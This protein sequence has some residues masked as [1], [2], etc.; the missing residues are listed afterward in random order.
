MPPAFADAEEFHELFRAVAAEATSGDD[1]LELQDSAPPPT[2]KKQKPGIG[3]VRQKVC[4]EDEEGLVGFDG[5]EW[6]ILRGKGKDWEC[7]PRKVRVREE[8]EED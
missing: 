2:A 4:L 6:E 5:K 3:C 7:G 8:L 1:K